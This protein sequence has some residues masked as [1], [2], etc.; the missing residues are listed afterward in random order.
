MNIKMY[1]SLATVIGAEFLKDYGVDFD[2]FRWESR[3]YVDIDLA[4][5]STFK[6]LELKNAIA[7]YP[8]HKGAQAALKDIGI[9]IEANKDVDGAKAN[10]VKQFFTLLQKYML[11]SVPGQRLFSHDAGRDA[12]FCYYVYSISYTPPQRS[13][14][15]VSPDYVTVN[16]AYR[17]FG[18]NETASFTLYDKNVRHLTVA[19]V[20]AEAE[21]I[22]ETS[23]LRAIYLEQMTKYESWHDQ[24]GKQFWATG[25][26]DDDG[27]DGNPGSKQRDHWYWRQT[28][29]FR[30]DK[31]GEPG[32][33]LI[34]VFQEE[35]K[36]SRDSDSRSKIDPLFWLKI[37][38]AQPDEDGDINEVSDEDVT[39]MDNVELEPLHIP[40][41][42]L[43]CVFDLNKHLRLRVHV[44]QLT[45]YVYDRQMGDR[46][47]LPAE[48]RDLI[49]ILLAHKST[50]ADVVAGKGGGSVVLCTGG[51][52][53]GKTLTAEIYSEVAAKPLYTVQCSQLGTKP[54]EIEG[55]LLKCMARAERWGAI[56]LL[57]ESD[58]YIRTRGDDLTQ[59]AIVGVF[60]RVLEYY[61]GVMFMT[62]N[63]PDMVDDAIAS[64]CV[65]RIQY[66][67][68]TPERQA[69]IWTG[70][71]KM[72]GVEFPAKEIKAVVAEY[73]SLSGRDVKNLMKLA[74]LVT[75]AKGEAHITAKTIRIVK[76][77]KSTN[78]LVKEP[79][80][81]AKR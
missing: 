31:N 12:W 2:S 45:E 66:E 51:P 38:K 78:D 37:Q 64:R 54:D 13:R 72:N 23:D 3:K 77:F 48:D 50:F 40:I 30:L 39:N 25:D 67:V 41:H 73:P 16:L 58:V 34:D 74:L 43:V 62:T 76:R 42:P 32:R 63:R 24:L 65:A 27:I 4:R 80:I 33:V 14:D 81:N 44:T 52:G 35:D 21:Y 68:P 61:R 46:L 19:Q 59:N 29:S 10:N 75:E 5:F 18:Q 11:K 1:Q 8:A 7:E 69:L 6:V 20:L 70:V 79:V 57:D 17:E 49:D 9:W 26:A 56:L 47:V 22:P 55:N 60:L 15:W 71:A 28:N 36:N 53:L